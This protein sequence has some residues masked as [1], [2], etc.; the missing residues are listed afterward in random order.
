MEMLA[1]G[2][3]VSWAEASAT[4]G[5]HPTPSSGHQ[6]VPLPTLHAM[7][8]LHLPGCHA[9]PVLEPDTSQACAC[10]PS[11]KQGAFAG[12]EH[13]GHLQQAP[14][15]PGGAPPERLQVWLVS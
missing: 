4:T 8:L 10:R 2:K 5:P 1:V 6:G 13:A 3:G 14:G 7:G 11:P 9:P 15:L 12:W